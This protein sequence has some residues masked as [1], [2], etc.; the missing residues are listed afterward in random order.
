MYGCGHQFV[1][2]S[3]RRTDDRFSRL[4]SGQSSRGKF[5]L[6]CPSAMIKPWW[7]FFAKALMACTIWAKW[8]RGSP[9]ENQLK[10]NSGCHPVALTHVEDPRHVSLLI[11][12]VWDTI[13]HMFMFE[14]LLRITAIAVR[15]IMQPML[16]GRRKAEKKH[17]SNRGQ[18]GPNE[19]DNHLGQG[20]NLMV[21]CFAW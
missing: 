13:E 19:E 14:I 4:L 9:V 8:R 2:F 20:L 3:G 1:H 12:M 18:L 21:A 7:F 10:S 6:L 17:A 5:C 15:D 16:G 11:V